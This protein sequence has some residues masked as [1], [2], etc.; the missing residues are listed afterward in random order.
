[1]KTGKGFTLLE[2]LI[3]LTLLTIVLGAVYSSFFSAQRAFER[4]NT[5][6]LKYHEA[7]TALDI[8]RREIEAAILEDS[9]SGDQ[10]VQKKDIINSTEF[11]MKDRDVMGK[12]SSELALT[13]LSFKGNA[14]TTSSYY[15]E[16]KDG[17]MNLI[18]KEAPLGSQSAGYTME[19]IDGI[20]GFTVETFFNARWVKTWDTKNT[21]SLPEVV[22]IG[23]EFD[24]NGKKVR[25]VEYARPR[26]GKKL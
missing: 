9:D 2:V 17:K 18:K 20:E 12:N 22:R 7:R 15:T 13:S 6:S 21:G 4:F 5:V 10:N 19:M 1:M 23:I 8:M 16:E 11:V 14:V 24:D 3:S 26:I 25:L